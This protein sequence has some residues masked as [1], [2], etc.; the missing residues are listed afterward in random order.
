MGN[1]MAQGKFK[2][3]VGAEDSSEHGPSQVIARERGPFGHVAH[4]LSETRHVR[5]IDIR[6]PRMAD[7]KLKRLIEQR[8]AVNARIRQE[9]ARLAADERRADTRRK[10]LA[11]AAVLQWAAKDSDFS[12]RLMAELKH[13]LVRDADRALFGL[14]PQLSTSGART[15]LERP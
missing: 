8:D 4:T 7:H 9:Q 5:S 14:P 12:T 6:A 11:G 15:H 1:F 3:L 10:I 13:F 2:Q